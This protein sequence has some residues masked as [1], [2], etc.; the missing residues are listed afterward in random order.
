MAAVLSISLPSGSVAVRIWPPFEPS[1]SGWIVNVIGMPVVSVFD[2]Q[3]SRI[4]PD[5][6]L[7]ISIIHLCGQCRTRARAKPTILRM[8]KAPFFFGKGFRNAPLTI[9]AQ[10]QHAPANNLLLPHD[11]VY[12]RLS[13]HA[14]EVVLWHGR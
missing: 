12:A 10:G 2:L 11:G 1:R 3:P 6:L 4:R 14:V 13:P 7:F 9:I 5:G 8:V